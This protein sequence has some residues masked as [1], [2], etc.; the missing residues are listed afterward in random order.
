[1]SESRS[2]WKTVAVWIGAIVLFAV[3]AHTVL[4]GGTNRR[5]AAEIAYIKARGEP[6]RGAD[7]A[8]PKIPDSENG[9]VVYERAIQ[10]F[11]APAMQADMN[12]I[13]SFDASTTDPNDWAKIAPSLAKAGP[14]KTLVAEAQTKPHCR[15]PVDW[16]AGPAALFPHYARMRAFARVLRTDAVAN[17]QAHRSDEAVKSLKLA[18]GLDQ[19][20]SKEPCLIGQLVRLAALAITHDGLQSCLRRTRLNEKQAKELFDQLGRIDLAGGHVRAML[21]ERAM[22]MWC[23]DHASEL[24]PVGLSNLTGSGSQGFGPTSLMGTYPLRPLLNVDQAA[25]LHFM[26]KQIEYSSHSAL[27]IKRK[28]LKPPDENDVPK[29]AVIS[30]ILMPVFS[31]ARMATDRSIAQVALARAAL[32]MEAYRARY[33]SWPASIA[34]AEQKLGWKLPKDPF[35]GRDLVYKK[36]IGGYVL[37]SLGLNMRDDSGIGSLTSGYDPKEPSDIVWECGP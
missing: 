23:F 24:G 16:A 28:G 20:I 35:S 8:G 15:F 9:A 1:M 34:D 33:G 26:R 37:Y 6:V 12:A 5:V 13:E 18:Y 36:T 32:A 21:G 29:Y 7:L 25:Y 22:G 11:A 10:M 2:A 3:V 31:R 19:S 4:V 17:A 14:L 30:R 27:E